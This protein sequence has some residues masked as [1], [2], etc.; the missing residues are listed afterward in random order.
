MDVD[1][2][3]FCGENSTDFD[4]FQW[5]LDSTVYNMCFVDLLSAGIQTVFLVLTSL[6]LL[7]VGC[8]TSFRRYSSKTLIQFPGHDIRWVVFFV[9]WVVLLAGLA[10][11]IVT[12]LTRHAGST[13]PHLYVPAIASFVTLPV[14]MVYYHHMECWQLPHMSWL[15]LLYW[16][17]AAGGEAVKTV[18]M[19][20]QGLDYTILRL[21]VAIA[22]LVL[23]TINILVELTI[24]FTKI[25]GCC[26]YEEPIPHRDLRKNDMYF[27]HEYVNLPS[28][29]SFWWLNWLLKTGYE[30]DLELPDLGK[31][32][33]DEG[34]KHHYELFSKAYE[35]E[36][37]RAEKK[38]QVPSIWRTFMTAYGKV[39]AWAG[40]L[41]FVGDSLGFISPV[42]LGGVVSYATVQY[43]G[44]PDS[45]TEHEDPFV[46]ITEFFTNGFVLVAVMFLASAAR[47][48]TLQYHYFLVIRESVHARA[49]IQ[50]FVYE[51]SLHLSSWTISSGEMT[52][53]QIT[54][55]MS[56]D[57]NTLLYFFQ[58]V[59][60]IWSVPYQI[61]VILLLLYLELG[62]AALIGSSVIL[63]TAPIQAVIGTAMSRVQKGTLKYSDDR[64]KKSNELLQGM[65]L[66]K[67][68]G[69]E[70]IFCS[71]IQEVRLKEI[72][73]MFR[74]GMLMVATM[75]VV[76]ST[77][78]IVTLV[79]FGLYPYLY[80]TP[81]TP[82][83]AFS[84]V[85]LFNQLNIPLML[86]PMV[87]GFTVNTMVSVRRLRKFFIAAEIEGKEDG[88]PRFKWGTGID[89]KGDLDEDDVMTK[90]KDMNSSG[91]V[92]VNGHSP[93][94]SPE[95]FPEV[96]VKDKRAPR[97]YRIS[98]DF[99]THEQEITL[100]EMPSG[101]SDEVA[102]KITNGG[103]SWESDSSEPYLSNIN[104][105]IPTGKL[106]MVAGL[107]GS[108]KS[109]LLSAMLG[110]MVTVSG[111]VL[112]NKDQS[113]VSYGAQKAWLQN[114][115]LRDNILFGEP[116]DGN[117]YQSVVEACA[118]QPDIDI[119]PA[120]D[121]TEIG[122]KGINLS[123]GQKQRI[124]V[125]RSI[126]SNSDIVILDDPL[127]ALD[128]HVG[129][130]LF[131]EGIIKLLIGA[132]RTVVLVTHQLQYL[133]HADKVIVVDDGK[134]KRQGTLDEIKTT[135]PELYA[136]WEETI[137]L[138][139]DGDEE[140]DD[141]EE[142]ETVEKERAKL[143]KQISLKEGEEKGKDASKGDL[144]K[145][146]ERETGSVS[147]H[148]YMAY[149][150]AL[151]IPAAIAIIV[152]SAL[153][154]AATAVTSFW[155][156]AWSEAGANSTNATTEEIKEDLV[157]YLSGYAILSVTSICLGVIGMT[158]NTV[159]SFRAAQRIHNALL[160]NIVHAPLRFFDTT[161]VGR[162]LNRFS[163]DTQL[164]DQRLSQT[165]IYLVRILFYLLTAIIVN[166]IAVPPFIAFI[167]PVAVV[168]YFIQRF[169]ITTS[170]ELQRLDN[171]NK[172][173]VFAHFSETLGGLSTIRAYRDERRFRRKLV[174]AINTSNTAFLYFQTA[175]RW[176]GVRLDFVGCF[177]VLLSGIGC[178]L[179]SVL[180]S[181]E[182]SLVGLSLSYS[183]SMT[184]YLNW[185]V[186]Q[187][188]DTETQMNSIE[189]V[190]YY[191]NVANEK[192]GG[193]IKPPAKWPSE[194]DIQI[195]QLSARYD[196]EL[197]PVLRNVTIR[198]RKGEKIGICGR[199]GSGKSSLTLSLFRMID[200]FAGRILI[201]G[202]DI[203]EVPLITLRSRLA[204]IPQ[205]P[206][207][208][209]G[210]I[211]FNLDPLGVTSDDEIWEALEIAQ[212]KSVVMELDGKL[213]SNVSEGGE[214]FSVGQR[215][216]F[217]LARAFLRKTRILVMDE[218]TASVDMQTD[219]ILQ[220]IVAT[221]FADRTVLTIA[222]RVA[223]IV[224]SDTILVLSD[225]KVIEYDTPQ[226]LLSQEDSV[227]ASLVKGST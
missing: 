197:D 102:I 18:D 203:S 154:I 52:M 65:K 147:L 32:S 155:L 41:K 47:L 114:N 132:N 59:H 108:G 64:L 70:E 129:K 81:L 133:Q 106:T 182:P 85:A 211:R 33:E 73:K 179:S 169:F 174:N 76:Q 214:N 164:I 199:T 99:E 134:I 137:N 21:D 26:G 150:K 171:I 60:Y 202:I 204:I 152:L 219:A 69:W 210:S 79:S 112:Y 221:A 17:A 186:R 53:G 167:I 168:Y 180:G 92:Q 160:Y 216:L 103:F 37:I 116:Y 89:Y 49:A 183:L 82:E 141:E 140:R 222:H 220:S 148:I 206:V 88:R 63:L 74:G 142:K 12:D 19:I 124:S 217:C 84:S 22:S 75:G 14:A 90:E 205:D 138:T 71:A 43:Y 100:D 128:V 87:I 121:M 118:L 28:R 27:Y 86:V 15:L 16:V 109:S 209:T 61:A 218:A 9:L 72:K 188:A 1:M 200:S 130:Q 68:Y 123:G 31:L 226:N 34:A 225:G 189:R 115:T 11:G 93:F 145:K 215:Q 25:C 207:L 213:D 144:I 146:E 56:V 13:Q 67:L 111:N 35:K 5:D 48:A 30:K 110:E 78:I 192:Y 23:Y 212:L 80:N 163:N 57:A 38:G 94:K 143:K 131:Q 158:F 42:A 44:S 120:G 98:G 176:L 208:F 77:P 224:D 119:L 58:T 10:E 95:V 122:E 178:M 201:D 166:V 191:T 45:S 20:D 223:T 190:E 196:T 161:P 194:G 105:E 117:R 187:V 39:M 113:K 3:W 177:V 156:S 195:E 8:C 185:L 227:F 101:M 151:R 127:S 36:K 104:I 66:L 162:I 165:L 46:T 96:K 4:Y 136:Q 7:I 173:P 153:A 50:T 83:V 139:D 135:D 29:I 157:Y 107:V 91:D 54:N 175:N 125:A 181:L 198:F 149:L 6:L 126:Y 51:K 170:R 24:I 159:F 97:K 2:D 55:H 184:A 193:K 172:S 62:Y 40:L